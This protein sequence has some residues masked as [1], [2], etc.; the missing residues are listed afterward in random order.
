MGNII[1]IGVS[2]I[3]KMLKHFFSAMFLDPNLP[4]NRCKILKIL[5]IVDVTQIF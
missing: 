4:N 5:L 3:L 1:N 2:I